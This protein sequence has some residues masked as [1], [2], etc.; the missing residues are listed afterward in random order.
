MS[1]KSKTRLP[2]R[3]K[4]ASRKSDAPVKFYK[5]IAFSFIALTCILI[6]FVGYFLLSKA[7]IMIKVV[8]EPISVDFIADVRESDFSNIDDYQEAVLGGK[9]LET[10][11]SGSKDYATTGI[12]FSEGDVGGKVTLFNNYGKDQPLVKT[13]RLLSKEGILY[14]LKERVNVPAGGKIEAEVYAD[15]PT[16]ESATLGPTTFIIPGLW[17]GLQDK[18]YAQSF[19]SMHGGKREVKFATAEDIENAF[20]DLT[21]SLTEEV[22][23]N[24]KTQMKSSGEILGKIIIKDFDEKKS[25]L[26]EGNAGENFTV[27]LSINVVGIAFS[28]KDLEIAALEQLKRMVP[29]DKELS[30]I[31]YDGLTFVVE[32]YDLREREANM[33]VHIEGDVAM[34]TD[35]SVFDEDKFIGLDKE[36]IIKYLEVYPEIERATIKF[37]PFWV[38]KVP[39]LKNNIKVIIQ[40]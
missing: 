27:D 15:T 37:S 11:V 17:E 26:V 38:K 9:I 25:N 33:L 14:R 34:K 6:L 13:T 7:E 39:Q 16:E 5:S 23:T 28:K 4:R 29:Q 1:T 30:R 21:Q 32:R 36:K 19:G 20:D 22:L 8:N 12:K 18:I 2:R 40:K 3:K 31:D 24:L 35:N 10:S